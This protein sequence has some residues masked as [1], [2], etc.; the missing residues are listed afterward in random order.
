MKPIFHRQG[1]AVLLKVM[2]FSLGL[3]L[4]F[5]L[6][7]NLLPQVEGEAAQEQEIDLGALTMDGFVSLGETL[8]S[9]KGTCTLC[10]NSMGRAP[11]ILQLDM[12]AIAKE[13]LADETYQ[14]AATS[15]QDY[16]RE[17]ML[18]PSVYVV[19]GF[20]QKG[21]NDTVSPMPVV[22]KAPIQ[23]TD[24]EIDAVIAF[25]QAKDGNDVTVALPQGLPASEA[26]PAAGAKQAVVAALPAETAEQ[27]FSK[28]S[29]TAC[30]SV[31]G[32]TSP[33]GPELNTIASRLD[34]AQIRQSILDPNAVIAE[35]FDAGMMPLDFARKMTISELDL[36]VNYLAAEAAASQSGGQ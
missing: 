20:G 8:F 24:V 11:D 5:T 17:S 22:N 21:S 18:Q 35:G 14:G 31:A 26:A 25:M 27:A 19:K 1:G 3:T 36:V 4:V 16:L 15:V 30:H 2:L 29:C 23:L 12:V 28:F 13:H 6:I 33:V 10:H 7:A 32:T 9:G 34:K